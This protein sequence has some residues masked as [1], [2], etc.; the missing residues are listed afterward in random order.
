MNHSAHYLSKTVWKVTAQDKIL[1]QRQAIT[2]D[3]RFPVILTEGNPKYWKVKL[4][5]DS[6]V[7]FLLFLPTR[8]RLAAG[9]VSLGKS[10]HSVLRKLATLRAC[11]DLLMPKGFPLPWWCVRLWAFESSNALAENSLPIWPCLAFLIQEVEEGGG[12]KQAGRDAPL[13]L[14]SVGLMDRPALA[15]ASPQHRIFSSGCLLVSPLH[16]FN[17]VSPFGTEPCSYL[18]FSVSHFVNFFF[19]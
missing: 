12:A 2:V 1:K 19:C 11:E 4:Y 6:W 9:F 5:K 8:Q 18:F 13:P 15:N 16:L 17:T 3:K 7:Y 10:R 14:A